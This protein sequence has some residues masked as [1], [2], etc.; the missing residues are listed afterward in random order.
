MLQ[1][2]MFSEAKYFAILLHQLVEKVGLRLMLASDN[3]VSLSALFRPP[4][5]MIAAI[6]EVL[7]VSA[8]HHQSL[9]CFFPPCLQL[10]KRISLPL[11]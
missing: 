2:G 11:F 6:E 3:S 10:S 4:Q 9:L 7:C 1:Q 5:A 8:L